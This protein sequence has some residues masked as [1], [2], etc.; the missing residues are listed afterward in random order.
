MNISSLVVHTRPEFLPSLKKELENLP[1]TEVHGTSD[2]G[3][4]VITIEDNAAQSAAD[5]M[6]AVQNM[7]GVLSAALAYHYF[8]DN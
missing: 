5:T 3:R 1:G 4:V 6:L 7:K 2:D 8:D